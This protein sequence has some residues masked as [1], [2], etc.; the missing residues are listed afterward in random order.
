MLRHIHYEAAFEDY[1]RSRA[2][3]YVPVDEA[4]RSIFAGER[5][6]SFDF[7]VYPGGDRRW[8]VDVKGRRFPY[9]TERGGRRYWENWVTREDLQ[10]LSEW[11][12]VFGSDFESR[13][14]FAYLLEGPPDRW[15]TL[16]PHS[17]RGDDYAFVAVRLDDYREH[18]RPRSSS[19]DTVSMSMRRFREICQ[20][21]ELFAP[22]RT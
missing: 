18:A 19:W 3:P 6:K 16:R 12:N 15:P 13:L 10:G 5:I 2:V 4:R 22:A 20:P 17:F 7:I 1:L 8:L 11:Q 14:V 9:I 21:V